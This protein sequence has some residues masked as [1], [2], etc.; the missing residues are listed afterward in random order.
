MI[1]GSLLMSVPAVL[2]IPYIGESFSFWVWGFRIIQGIGA[3]AHFSSFFTL[4]AEVAQTGKRNESIA[5]YGI[6]GLGANI[7]APLFGEWLTE[8]YGLNYFFMMVTSFG[9]LATI[10]AFMIKTPTK[11]TIANVFALG[12]IK[13]AFFAKELRLPYI[14]SFILSIP[15]AMPLMFLAPFAK[16]IG[17]TGFTLFF[18]GYAVTGIVTR[19]IG[20]G[21]ADKIG[22]RRILIPLFSIFAL[23]MIVIG[24]SE[25][26]MS[27]IFAG[28]LG[29]I[30]HALAFPAVISLGYSFA[31][32]HVKGSAVAILTGT[33]DLGFFISGIVFGQ[34][35]S[36]WG[37]QNIFYV[38]ALIPL[39]GAL[40]LTWHIFAHPEH[41]SSR[42]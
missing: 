3:G 9:L 18:T 14:L 8:V 31:P 27:L 5:M 35:A 41:L 33:M 2:Y 30:V 4:A 29:G 7:I 42:S 16:E 39:S 40:L 38:S 22:W 15:V 17:L 11:S 34:L 13:I 36:F 28:L 20:K 12:Q 24:L 25:T 37:Y 26:R 32:K 23:S 10:M 6:S 21:W 1:L 19:L